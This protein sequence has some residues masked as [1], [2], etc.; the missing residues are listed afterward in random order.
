M[1]IVAFMNALRDLCHDEL[2]GM[3]FQVAV[4]KGDT[5]EVFKEPH[6][7]LMRLPDVENADKLA[8]YFIIQPGKSYHIQKPGDEPRFFVPVRMVFCTYC[9]DN[10]RGEV[11]L[12]NIMERIR[13]RLLKDVTFGGSFMLDVNEPLELEPYYEDLG[14]Y[15]AGELRGTFVLPPIIREVEGFGKDQNRIRNSDHGRGDSFGSLGSFG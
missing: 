14:S 1:T 5:E 3:T 10:E 2:K 6:G 12:M 11:E 15:H 9:D 7:Y 8:P 13:I 4:Q